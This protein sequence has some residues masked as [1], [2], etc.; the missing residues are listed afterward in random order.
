MADIPGWAFF[1][2]GLFVD[3]FSLYVG[4]QN[5]LK[6]FLVFFI[7]GTLLIAFG[8]YKMIFIKNPDEKNKLYLDHIMEQKAKYESMRQNPQ[9]QQQV[10]QQIYQQ[11][12]SQMRPQA[13]RVQGYPQAQRNISQ[14]RVKEYHSR[15]AEAYRRR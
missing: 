11:G 3:L 15:L 2:A 7:I 6:R 4:V 8:V 10:R 14:E 12:Q 1:L 9:Y 5:E 13:P